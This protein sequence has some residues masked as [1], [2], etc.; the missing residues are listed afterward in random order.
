[1]LFCIFPP[2]P[3]KCPCFFPCECPLP[4]LILKSV[5]NVDTRSP[6]AR[7][8]LNSGRASQSLSLL[9][10]IGLPASQAL[11]LFLFKSYAEKAP[12][13]LFAIL[14]FLCLAIDSIFILSLILARSHR[15]RALKRLMSEEAKRL[16]L[17]LDLCLLET[18]A[19]RLNLEALEP[20]LAERGKSEVCREIHQEL[21]A[22]KES[23]IRQ[24]AGLSSAGGDSRAFFAAFEQESARL[25][26]IGD[27]LHAKAQALGSVLG[28]I[29]QEF[30][31]DRSGVAS[32]FFF[33][34]E[35]IGI[36]DRMSDESNVYATGKMQAILAAFHDLSSYSADIGRDVS[37]ILRD[38][39]DTSRPTSLGAISRESGLISS[40]LDLFFGDLDSLRGFS[41]T[42]VSANAKQLANIRRMAEGIEDFSETIRLISMNVS[43]E[44]ARLN[45]SGVGTGVKQ[46]GRGFQVLAK[47]LSD[48]A[49]KA[50]DLAREERRTIDEAENALMGVNADFVRHLDELISRVPRIKRRLDPFE[51]IINHSFDNLG[52]V[53]KALGSLAEA[54][55]ARLK[56]VI[57]QMQFQDLSRQEVEHIIDFLR[58]GFSL[59]GRELRAMTSKE[60]LS[61]QRLL[62]LRQGLA[63]E[64]RRL[65]TTLNEQRVIDAY[66][67]EHGM[68]VDE[69]S[70]NRGLADGSIEL[71]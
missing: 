50:Q 47:N 32:F 66:R 2:A 48:F 19:H 69:G 4:A 6:Q 42:I 3:G 25:S 38:I 22:I 51:G 55:D 28:A 35:S 8:L 29:F 40:D 64:Y 34:E 7:D 49:F 58:S 31:K 39:M 37:G 71:F 11:M 57:G 68:A 70:D 5:K 13:G 33:L 24:K 23:V 41:D 65:S 36:L 14:I 45:S 21:V 63:T 59:H 56:A 67:A 1:M 52:G 18:E 53:V 12:A 43:I 27:S 46:A 17:V 15:V 20:I 30:S 61:P 54:V 10:L 26:E 16:S 60:G 62:E 44:A 9:F